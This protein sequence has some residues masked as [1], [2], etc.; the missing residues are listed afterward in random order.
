M[1]LNLCTGI[2]AIVIKSSIGFADII[3]VLTR[4]SEIVNIVFAMMLSFTRKPIF[5]VPNAPAT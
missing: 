2:F 3:F 1:K 5:G 4:S